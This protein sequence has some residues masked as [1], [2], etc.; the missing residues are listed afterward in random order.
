MST[1][2]EPVV[3]ECEGDHLIGILC[4]PGAERSTGVLIA[5]GGPQYRVG[6]HR[7][8]VQLARALAN[9]GYP[10]FRFDYRGMGDSSGDQRSFES[11]DADL[12]SA[13]AEFRA[14]VPTMQRLV[15]FG[16]CDAASAALLSVGNIAGVAGL[17]LANPWVRRPDSHNATVVRHYYTA[18]LVSRAFWTKLISGRVSLLQS[19]GEALRRVLAMIRA[20]SVGSGSPSHPDFVTRMLSGWQRFP[21]NRLLILSE[22]DL[23]A[24]EFAETFHA[25]PGWSRV[26]KTA[27]VET[28]AIHGAD[29]TFS[30]AEHRAAVER[31]CIEFLHGLA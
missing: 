5:V 29:H 2:E 11:V 28:H 22:R 19:A 30:A 12:S 14:R 16:L 26:P 10:T 13:V 6:S 4:R 25:D 27:H 3:F 23:T 21:G 18:R 7:Q 31:A 15:I 24:K 17:I 8:F 1:A 20:T 9:V